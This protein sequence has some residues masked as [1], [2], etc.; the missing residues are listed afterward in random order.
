MI[1][2]NRIEITDE[3]THYRNTFKIL[4]R[5][6]ESDELFIINEEN[7]RTVSQFGDE[8]MRG[9]MTSD[10]TET[11]THV[12][13]PGDI[14]LGDSLFERAIQ[15]IVSRFIMRQFRNTMSTMKE[16]IETESVDPEIHL[17]RRIDRLRWHRRRAVE[18]HQNCLLQ[19]SGRIL[20]R[21]IRVGEPLRWQLSTDSGNRP[22]VH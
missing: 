1:D 2:I 9:E 19:L 15:P 4:G 3:D 18:S 6:T 8:S 7:Y 21:V 16:L 22:G 13:L 12:R 14:E 20:R 11:K 17:K 10:Y 5:T